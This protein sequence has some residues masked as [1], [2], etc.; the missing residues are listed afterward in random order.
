MFKENFIFLVSFL[1]QLFRK[2]RLC[3]FTLMDGLVYLST[4]YYFIFQSNFVL[5]E[6]YADTA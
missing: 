6:L 1:L 5:N 4:E 3:S 2:N